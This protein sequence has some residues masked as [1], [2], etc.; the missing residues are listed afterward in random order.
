[1]KRGL[2]GFLTVIMMLG[3][4][5]AFV[6]QA[7]ADMPR[8]N[9]PDVQFK[10]SRLSDDGRVTVYFNPEIHGTPNPD[11]YAEMWKVVDKHFLKGARRKAYR[12]EIH[13]SRYEGFLAGLEEKQPGSTAGIT[14]GSQLFQAYTYIK[15]DGERPT[16][17]IETYQPMDDNTFVHE[18]LHH[19]FEQMAL[20][21]SMNSHRII[22]DY[23]THVESL[24][25]FMLG[26]LY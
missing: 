1:M 7:A 2:V 12:L 4:F 19:Y 24:L 3:I 21:G 26:K 18:L 11:R 17:V 22:P 23:A 14:S 8:F 9:P 20:D 15:A 6:A 13:Y 10:A 5:L 16:I 25:R